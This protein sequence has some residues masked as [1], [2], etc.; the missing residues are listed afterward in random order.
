VV[1][2]VVTLC[3]QVLVLCPVAT[4][5]PLVLTL[6]SMDDGVPRCHYHDMSTRDLC[7]IHAVYRASLRFLVH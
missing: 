7:G 2:T 1:P 3:P 5:M 4:C 6:Q